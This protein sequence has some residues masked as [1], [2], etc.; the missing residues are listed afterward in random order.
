M[1]SARS[2]DSSA[3]PSSWLRTSACQSGMGH[4]L[5]PPQSLEEFRPFLAERRYLFLSC[6]SEAITAAAAAVITGFPTAA[7]PAALLHAVEHGIQGGE[8]EAQRAFGLPLDAASHL[9]T[10]ERAV[11]QNAE[12]GKLCGTAFDSCANHRLPPYM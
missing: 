4:L 7:N 8:R 11:F 2:C 9:I 12:N 10:V 1:T 3:S 6:G 5:E